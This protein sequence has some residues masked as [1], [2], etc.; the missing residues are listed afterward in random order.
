MT[1][2]EEDVEH[3]ANLARITLTPEERKSSIKEFKSIIEL[4]SRL[5]EVEEDV[6]PT[7]HVLPLKNVFREDVAGECLTTDE[8]LS[9]A[10]R[11]E[12]DYFRGPRIV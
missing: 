4:F 8:A 2:K 11:R 6:E 9:N 12:G 1:I 3:A 10:P 7:Y 5:D